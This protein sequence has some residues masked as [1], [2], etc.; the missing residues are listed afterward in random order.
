LC[1]ADEEEGAIFMVTTRDEREKDLR[2]IAAEDCIRL[3]RIYQGAIGTPYGQI[4]IP[5]IATSRMIEII[6][7][8]EF[9]P[10]AAS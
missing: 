4:P 8:K 9:P 5:G 2:A 6:L 7:R 10:Q 3:V 1:Q